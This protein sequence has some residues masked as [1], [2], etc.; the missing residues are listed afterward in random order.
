MARRERRAARRVWALIADRVD[1]GK[2]K[3]EFVKMYAEAFTTQSALTDSAAAR[4]DW[5]TA[6]CLCPELMVGAAGL[7]P[8]TL[9][10]EGRCS[11]HLSYAPMT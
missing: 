5:A 6:P 11:I 9:C 3:A 2:G 10:L 4:T 7:E 1:V 8:A